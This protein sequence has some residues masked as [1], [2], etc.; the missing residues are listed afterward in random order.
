MG[1]V[2]GEAC[3]RP[4]FVGGGDVD[5]SARQSA[6]ASLDCEMIV[7]WLGAAGAV[8]LAKGSDGY[9]R[10]DYQAFRDEAAGG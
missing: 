6:C 4:L 10:A 1:S 7:R 2:K 5:K 9:G 3:E 8:A